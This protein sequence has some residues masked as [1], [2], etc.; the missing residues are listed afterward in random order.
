MAAWQLRSV[1]WS[2]GKVRHHAASRGWRRIHAGVYALTQAAPTQ[3]Q[4]WW[5][6]ALSSPDSQLSHGSGGACFGFYRFNRTYEVITRPGRGGRRRSGGLLVFR[7]TFLDGETTTHLG[8]PIVTAERVL[9]ELTPGLNEKQAGRCF[10]EAI[11]LKLTTAAKV[12]RAVDRRGGQPH[13]LRELARRYEHVPYHRTRSDPEGRALELLHDAG[14]ELP[15]VNIRVAGEEADL[16]DLGRR[17]IIEIDGPQYHQFPAEDARK[18]ARWHAAGFT[19]RRIPS[20]AVYDDPS[21][22]IA[23]FVDPPDAPAD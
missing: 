8:I 15:Q 22:L 2:V 6:A 17:R 23:L 5:A 4:L 20:D 10:R 9:A 13:L 16:V 19:V 7:S 12:T 1:G 14:F 11:R 3:L 21:R 18:A